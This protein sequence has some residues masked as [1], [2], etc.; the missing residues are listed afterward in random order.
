MSIRFVLLFLFGS[1]CAN[2]V[3]QATDDCPS[4]QAFGDSS[5]A[6]FLEFADEGYVTRIY[7]ADL[8][9]LQTDSAAYQLLLPHFGE[10]AR[11][12]SELDLRLSY[13]DF[14]E[15]W[16]L[17]LP[18]RRVARIECARYPDALRRFD[19]AVPDSLA[20]SEDRLF[21]EHVGGSRA[22]SSY[23]HLRLAIDR[24]VP[25]PAAAPTVRGTYLPN[26]ANEPVPVQFAEVT[27]APG[28]QEL[29]LQYGTLDSYQNVPLYDVSPG[30]GRYEEVND[31]F[32][33]YT[34]RAYV[35]DTLQP[36]LLALRV[37]DFSALKP[38]GKESDAGFFPD[39]EI[40]YPLSAGQLIADLRS[41][42]VTW[43]PALPDLVFGQSTPTAPT[44]PDRVPTDEV[45]FDAGPLLRYQPIGPFDLTYFPTKG[46]QTGPVGIQER[47]TPAADGWQLALMLAQAAAQEEDPRVAEVTRLLTAFNELDGLR[48]PEHYAEALTKVK[49]V[50]QTYDLGLAPPYPTE[51][52]PLRERLVEA[53]TDK[54][55]KDLLQQVA[56]GQKQEAGGQVEALLPITVHLDGETGL[57]RRSQW[58]VLGTE[59]TLRYDT[60]QVTMVAANAEQGRDSLTVPLPTGSLDLFQFRHQLGYL[61]L[62]TGYVTTLP[63]FAVAV[64]QR[65]SY[66]SQG[67]P[68]EAVTLEPVYLRVKATVQGVERPEGAA[69]DWYRVQVQWDGVPQMLPFFEG[70]PEQYGGPVEGTYWLTRSAPHRLR[71]VDYDGR[72]G[73]QSK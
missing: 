14:W 29:T 9:A 20:L 48:G 73:L 40:E 42:D 23:F 68:R 34:H 26:S 59:I 49:Q 31:Y 44:A 11:Q 6:S 16:E 10:N 69:E 54:Y 25:M 33:E 56:Q 45:D 72:R 41:T 50:N 2:A 65:R 4:Y 47:M 1:M 70:R 55:P 22:D 46:G 52:A 53:I 63:V 19:G 8:A 67:G 62:E 15:R 24:I 3:S 27:Y 43:Q 21:V 66:S 51:T 30:P 28:Q 5:A 32:G 13:D 39:V 38:Q 17:S 7:F 36:G 57:P 60:Q 37:Y 12:L 71:R 64:Q 61:P 18:R 58:S 35:I